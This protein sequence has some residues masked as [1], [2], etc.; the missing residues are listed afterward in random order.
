MWLQLELERGNNKGRRFERSH[1]SLNESSGW[2]E[3]VV[4]EVGG[5]QVANWLSGVKRQGE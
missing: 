3:G 4:G 1:L 5:N 2:K